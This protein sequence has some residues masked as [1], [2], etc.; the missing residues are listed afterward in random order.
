MRGAAAKLAYI[1]NKVTRYKYDRERCQDFLVR[2]ISLHC[3][4]NTS[5]NDTP[6]LRIQA[7]LDDRYASLVVN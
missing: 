5:Q 6:G 3:V 7:Q 4:Y 1:G 2:Y